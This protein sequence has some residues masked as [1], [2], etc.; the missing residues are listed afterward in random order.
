MNRE[1]TFSGA[2]RANRNCNISSRR[3]LPHSRPSRAC[4]RVHSSKGCC[5][6]LFGCA[7]C[8]PFLFARITDG[9][10]CY[11]RHCY[12]A[13]GDY[14]LCT[15]VWFDWG[16]IGAEKRQA[17]RGIFIWGA[18]RPYWMG[19]CIAWSRRRRDVQVPLLCRADSASGNR[20]QALRQRHRSRFVL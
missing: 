3:P 7:G 8:T 12:Y 18:Y 5:N 19:D 10:T 9:L 17:I 2:V 20:L 14:S 16:R 6:P 15:C 13:A 1:L 4:G 11:E